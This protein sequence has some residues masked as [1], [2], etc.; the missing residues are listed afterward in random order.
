MGA[1][2]TFDTS[3]LKPKSAKKQTTPASNKALAIHLR[4]VRLLN[5]SMRGP[6]W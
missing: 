3:S 5:N 4:N 2:P 1:L 6:T